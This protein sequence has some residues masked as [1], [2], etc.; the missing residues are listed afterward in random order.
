MGNVVSVRI[1]KSSYI[2]K[3]KDYVWF[4]TVIGMGSVGNHVVVRLPKGHSNT[5]IWWY[6]YSTGHQYRFTRHALFS[7]MLVS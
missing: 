6:R 4:G 1:V 7:K 5:D 3:G 2:F